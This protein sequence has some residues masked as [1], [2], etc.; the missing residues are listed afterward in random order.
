MNFCS[1]R[2]NSLCTASLSERNSSVWYVNHWRLVSWYDNFLFQVHPV[3][4]LVCDMSHTV[5]VVKS[6]PWLSTSESIFL[7]QLHDL[8]YK[9]D[10]TPAVRHF[11]LYSAA[12]PFA[13]W[14]AHRLAEYLLL[15]HKY[16][17]VSLKWE[18]VTHLRTEI[19]RIWQSTSL[20]VE[21]SLVCSG[22]QMW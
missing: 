4:L 14:W 8:E 2:I 7:A 13:H 5:A 15:L 1:R 16:L 18:Q 22:W 19:D 11:Q 21:A 10:H 12:W 9:I 17:H 6:H 20:V 3:C